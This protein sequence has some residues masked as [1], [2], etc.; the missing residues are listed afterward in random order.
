V[1]QQFA[2][3]TRLARLTGGSL[4]IAAYIGLLATI[5][6]AVVGLV[7]IEPFRE[8]KIRGS[9]WSL[10][11]YDEVLTRWL[12]PISALSVIAL[13]AYPFM[14]RFRQN[15]KPMPGLLKLITAFLLVATVVSWVIIGVSSFRQSG[16]QHEDNAISPSGAF[17]LASK[18]GY[19]KQGNLYIVYQCNPGGMNC[20]RIYAEHHIGL[21][22]YSIKGKESTI[23]F[24]PQ[25][26]TVI[27]NLRRIRQTVNVPVPN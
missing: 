23:N 9:Y 20:Q 14:Q 13:I 26:N 5:A 12:G 4:R 16:F 7:V 19:G 2:Q 15:Y 27:L 18:S 21:V 17:F 25:T 3:L 10:I 11:I 8:G 24:N 22:N 1:E 6:F